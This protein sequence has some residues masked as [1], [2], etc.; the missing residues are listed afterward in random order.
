M[1]RM[2]PRIS[3]GASGLGSN[4]SWCVTP[5]GSQRK[6]LVSGGGQRHP[7]TTQQAAAVQVQGREG[8]GH[9]ETP[10]FGVVVGRRC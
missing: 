2:G 6:D 7:R 5:P 10:L 3:S 9:A 4:D 1:G 8:M